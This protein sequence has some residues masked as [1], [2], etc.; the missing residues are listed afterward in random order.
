MDTG[1]TIVVNSMSS[2]HNSPLC[3]PMTILASSHFCK[4]TKIGGL[5]R[6]GVSWV[7]F[8]K[9]PVGFRESGM[10]HHKTDDKELVNSFWSV[11]AKAS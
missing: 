9:M 10:I 2:R 11:F 4:Y 7:L 5:D 3:R 6:F 1:P 8:T